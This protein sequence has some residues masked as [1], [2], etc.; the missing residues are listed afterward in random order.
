[1]T[2]LQQGKADHSELVTLVSKLQQLR[3]PNNPVTVQQ[4]MTAV[5]P[6]PP[7]TTS[8]RRMG[9][10]PHEINGCLCPSSSPLPYSLLPSSPMFCHALPCSPIP[11]PLLRSPAMSSAPLPSPAPPAL[12]PPTLTPSI[13]PSVSLP[14]TGCVLGVADR[15]QASAGRKLKATVGTP[16]LREIPTETATEHRFKTS[17]QILINSIPKSALEFPNM[18][19]GAAAP[20]PTRPS[21]ARASTRVSNFE[22]TTRNL[23]RRL[24]GTA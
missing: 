18:W 12:T 13:P 16:T 14:V 24:D 11:C 6:M 10:T 22:Q 8:P 7:G 1:M 20:R 19:L 23:V 17:E 21:S 15:V 9:A 4:L 2:E 3:Q 5:Y